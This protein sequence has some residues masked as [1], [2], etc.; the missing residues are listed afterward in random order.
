MLELILRACGLA[1]PGRAMTPV[2]FVPQLGNN[3]HSPLQT[4]QV[5]G[6]T[7]EVAVSRML[8]IYAHLS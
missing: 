2:F 8:L 1:S 4:M 6:A 5:L 7:P 3:T